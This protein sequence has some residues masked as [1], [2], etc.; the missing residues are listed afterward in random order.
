MRIHSLLIASATATLLAFPAMAQQPGTP[1]RYLGLFKYSD[2]AMKGMREN[3][4]DRSAAISKLYETYGV[5][6][7]A[8]YAFPMGGEYD[9]LLIIQ[10]PSDS[11][12]EAVQLV[13][14]AGG[15]TAKTVVVPV[16]APNEF[17]A[18]MEAA[19]Q[20]AASYAPPGR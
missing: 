16:I 13:T 11:A 18:L 15:A 3:P 5:K 1:H 6:L 7:E 2:Q 14:R 4:Q 8:A 10:A 19:K 17:R 12:I 20:G 9:A